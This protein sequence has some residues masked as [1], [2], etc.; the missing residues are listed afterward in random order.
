MVVFE[1]FCC[2][3]VFLGVEKGVGLK[4]GMMGSL[5]WEMEYFGLL[6]FLWLG[7]YIEFVGGGGFYLVVCLWEVFLWSL[8]LVVCDVVVKSV[9]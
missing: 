3:M 7:V 8:G 6:G 2:G 1:I 9:M 5:W 4:L